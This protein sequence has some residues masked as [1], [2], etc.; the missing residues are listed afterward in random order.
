MTVRVE[1]AVAVETWQEFMLA[2]HPGCTFHDYQTTFASTP[3]REIPPRLEE[4]LSEFGEH[5]HSAVFALHQS[6]IMG[7][8]ADAHHN[9]I[10][11]EFSM[12]SGDEFDGITVHSI[13]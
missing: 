10:A 1:T 8:W 4:I 13:G 11:I 7:F 5:G 12:A 9:Y 2:A 6:A 3:T